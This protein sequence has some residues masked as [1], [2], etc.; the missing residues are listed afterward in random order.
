MRKFSKIFAALLTLAIVIGSIVVISGALVPKA[1]TDFGKSDNFETTAVGKNA[2]GFGSG[3][4][5]A[6]TYSTKVVVRNEETGNQYL[7]YSFIKGAAPKA[8]R[9]DYEFAPY[10]SSAPTTHIADYS[11]FTVDFDVCADAYAYEIDGVTYTSREVPEEAQNVRLAYSPSTYFSID[12]RL[13]N[14]ESYP[15]GYSVITVTFRYENDA[16]RLFIGGKDTGYTLSDKLD[17]WNHFTYAVKVIAKEVEVNGETKITYG[18]SEVRFYLDGMFVSSSDISSTNKNVAYDINPRAI[19]WYISDLNTPYS[20]GIDNFTPTFYYAGYSSGKAYGIDDLFDEDKSTPIMFCEDVKYDRNYVVPGNPY[21]S[22]DTGATKTYMKY[23]L[24]DV[25]AKLKTGD[26]I[27]TGFDIVNFTPNENVESFE[28]YLLDNAIF[29]LSE[30]AL[31][32]YD[33]VKSALGYKVTKKS[34]PAGLKLNLLDSK[35]GT[36]IASVMLYANEAPVIDLDVVSQINL[37]TGSIDKYTVGEWRWDIDGDSGDTEYDFKDE[38]VRAL[39]DIEMEIAKQYWDGEIDVY[40][41]ELTPIEEDVKDQLDYIVLVN[42]SSIWYKAGESLDVYYEITSLESRFA[43]IPSN[44]KVIL[45]EDVQFSESLKIKEN[46]KIEI[47]LNGNNII[48]TANALFV[49]SNNADVSIY[50]ASEAMIGVNSGALFTTVGATNFNNAN[51]TFGDAEKGNQLLASADIF[52]N[53]IT[54]NAMAND[55]KPVSVSINAVI[56]KGGFVIAAPDVEIEIN[57]TILYNEGVIFETLLDYEQFFAIDAKIAINNAAIISES[58]VLGDIAAN[59]SI[60]IS[61]ATVFGDLESQKYD[62]QGSVVI[63][64]GVEFSSDVRKEN[65]IVSLAEDVCFAVADYE[66]DLYGLTIN[67]KLIAVDVEEI[68]SEDFAIAI[69]KDATGKTFKEE[70][71]HKSDLTPNHPSAHEMKDEA[72]FP[73]VEDLGNGWYDRGYRTWKNANEE[74]SSDELIAGETTVFVPVADGV[75]P[76]VDFKLNV[77]LKSTAVSFN[78]YAAIPAEDAGVVIDP[79]SVYYVDVDGNKIPAELLVDLAGAEGYYAIEI[80][81]AVTDFSAKTVVIGFAVVGYEEEPIELEEVVEI[82]FLTYAEVATDLYSC[83]SEDAKLVLEVLRYKKAAADAA[84]AK[85]TSATVEKIDS[86]LAMHGESCKCLADL[87]SI[88]YTD[89]ELNASLGSLSDKILGAEYVVAGDK[90]D[91]YFYVDANVSVESFAIRHK[92]LLDQLGG[93]DYINY[94]IDV[95]L[96]PVAYVEYNGVKCAVYAY[97]DLALYNVSAIMNI[98]LTV[99]SASEEENAEPVIETLTGAYSLAAYIAEASDDCLDFASALY[100]AS[101]TALEFRF[102]REGEYN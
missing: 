5:S 74:A 72:K 3:T 71:Y 39:S 80:P 62:Q 13:F 27:E 64:S 52:L 102:I 66:Y 94:K 60:S 90:V 4:G 45:Y 46:A 53:L 11:Y 15:S 54:A 77:S 6:D 86:I 85:L 17:A 43:S 47:D 7:R 10:S 30:E 37:K 26:M 65:S 42:D 99:A 40:P 2:K 12:N 16:W 33:I 70:Y 82:D 32:K 57:N 83:G 20:M 89:A 56:V 68:N 18:Y 95:V 41:A 35:G 92:G 49:I 87:N 101:N 61:Q 24:N 34:A 81:L 96:E 25:L 1:T 69:W 48:S 75:V 14:G 79:A 55:A 51:I 97:D 58:N 19:D 22:L 38:L 63:G 50:S 91:L 59:T 9:R 67:V 31:E 23:F 93:W 98:S 28:V 100:A 88:E 76:A 8:Y 84:G 36:A 29:T 73:G 78:L 44:A 21:I